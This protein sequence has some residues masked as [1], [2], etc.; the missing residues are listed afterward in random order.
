[1]AEINITSRLPGVGE[2]I[3]S[4]MTALAQAHGAI[5]LSQGFPN[6]DCSEGLKELVFNAMR[7]GKNQYAPMVGVI[8]LRE[9]LA[10]KTGMLYGVYA[11]P[12]SEI[13]ITAGATQAI[14]TA[15]AA[16]VHPGDEVVLIEPA[17]DSYK[18]AILLQGG[19]PVVYTCKAPSFE[20]DWEKLGAL[21]TSRTRLILVNSPHNPTGRVFSEDDM[22]QLIRLTRDTS[23]MI[24]SDEVYEHLVY[25][26]ESHRSIWM[27]PELRE[28]SL[29]VYSFG[30]TFHNTGWKVGYCIGSSILMSEFRKVHQYNVFSVNTPVQHAL[31]AYIQEPAVYRGLAK[32]YE[33]KRNLFQSFLAG[34]RFKCLPCAGTYFQAVDYQAISDEPDDVFARRLTTGHGVAAIPVSAFYTN[35][36]DDRVLRFCFAKTDAVLEEAGKRL[37]SV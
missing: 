16:L 33:A 19:K 25:E 22:Q 34:S 31:A 15:I 17:Y 2:S 21:L 30:K 18:P 27:Y 11:D 9:A 13:T 8:E 3:F 35:A 5:N 1:M 23:I 7:A 36:P 14:F 29:A 10:Q 20:V 28:R 6:F 4:T 12:E 37:A 26:E 24:L 32:F